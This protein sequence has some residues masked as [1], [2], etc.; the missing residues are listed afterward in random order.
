MDY[1]GVLLG[2]FVVLGLIVQK[3]VS[4]EHKSARRFPSCRTCGKGM[5]LV[6]LPRFMPGEV[7]NHL[8]RHGLPTHAASRFICPEGH[9]Q[10]WYVPR[11][12]NTESPFFMK[13][14][15]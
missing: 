2:S 15:L 4:T 1:V 10:L 8:D 14:A 7:V 12:G 11:F 3:L 5:N 13:E 6:G 9:Y